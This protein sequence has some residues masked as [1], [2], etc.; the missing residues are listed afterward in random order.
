[1]DIDT[2]ALGRKALTDA[3]VKSAN[4]KPSQASKFVTGR[5]TPVV[6]LAL[7]IEEA[8]GIPPS[9]WAETHRHR[10]PAEMWARIQQETSK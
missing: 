4:L 10:R 9:F 7:K 1:M 2:E 3:L 6:D 5:A 8:T